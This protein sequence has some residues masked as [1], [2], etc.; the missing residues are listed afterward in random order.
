VRLALAWTKE[1]GGRSSSVLNGRRRKGLGGG[2]E[3]GRP[4]V[5]VETRRAEGLEDLD[6]WSYSAQK[7]GKFKR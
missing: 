4:Q 5:R 2:G 6:F 1:R 7:R 3:V